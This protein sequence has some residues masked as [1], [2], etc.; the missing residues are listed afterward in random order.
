MNTQNSR[1]D[2]ME[3]LS[4][5]RIHIYP[6][7][8]EEILTVV[9]PI[10]VDTTTHY[11]HSSNYKSIIATPRSDFGN[12]SGIE[13]THIYSPSTSYQGFSPNTRRD[14]ATQYFI[15]IK[16]THTIAE[17]FLSEEEEDLSPD[18]RNNRPNSYLLTRTQEKAVVSA[19]SLS[20]SE[21]DIPESVTEVSEED[22]TLV[23]AHSESLVSYIIKN[24]L[25]EGAFV[26]AIV[27][28]KQYQSLIQTIKIYRK[29]HKKRDVAF[30]PLYSLVAY[31]KTK[32][33]P[34]VT[35]SPLYDH[36]AYPKQV[37]LSE[38]V[39][40]DI[41]KHVALKEYN[42]ISVAV[43]V[44]RE[45]QAKVTAYRFP[46]QSQF[47]VVSSTIRSS[48]TKMNHSNYLIA[49]G[50]STTFQT[51]GIPF[52]EVYPSSKAFPDVVDK[53][54]Y[55]TQFVRNNS[56]TSVVSQMKDLDGVLDIQMILGKDY[57][58][59]IE[60]GGF[61]FGIRGGSK[62][63]KEA[64]LVVRSVEEDSP[65]DICGLREGDNIWAI[66]GI[67]IAKM[68]LPKAESLY[69]E[70][71]KSHD[72]TVKI[73][74]A[75]KKP[76]FKTSETVVFHKSIEQLPQKTNN[77]FPNKGAYEDEYGVDNHTFSGTKSPD[78]GTEQS[79][80][81]SGKG[82]ALNVST[83]S[84]NNHLRSGAL[85]S[86]TTSVINSTVL[87]FSPTSD[88]TTRSGVNSNQS[89]SPRTASNTSLAS[90]GMGDYRVSSLGERKGRV[91]RL[92]DFVPEVDRAGDRSR[93]LVEEHYSSHEEGYSS[94]IYDPQHSQPKMI[95]NYNYKMI[96]KSSQYSY[97]PTTYNK[98]PP[99]NQ[100]YRQYSYDE[101]IPETG[102]EY[103]SRS[104]ENVSELQR[105]PVMEIHPQF[106]KNKSAKAGGGKRSSAARKS[107]E[108][109][110]KRSM[111]EVRDNDSYV[112]A[113]SRRQS[114][115][116]DSRE[117]VYH[118]VSESI[119]KKESHKKKKKVNLKRQEPVLL[120]RQVIQPEDWI[121][122]GVVRFYDRDF[123]QL[124][125]AY[126]YDEISSNTQLE[127]HDALRN[128]VKQQRLPAPG[129]PYSKNRIDADHRFEAVSKTIEVQK[130]RKEKENKVML[131]SPQI[132]EEPMVIDKEQV[133]AVSGKNICARCNQE[134]GR[135]AAMIIESLGL[136]FHLSCFRC[137]TCSTALGNGTKG[138]DVRVRD[139]KLFCQNCYHL[140]AP[141]H[142]HET[143]KISSHLNRIHI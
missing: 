46:A 138:A 55:K 11:D 39:F 57:H 71:I 108:R 111:E 7:D 52:D 50:A 112:T 103:I 119:L 125:H 127:D 24:A 93:G 8:R 23:E 25:E 102:K 128:I 106:R 143:T 134:L 21:I 130:A 41:K 53:Q 9:S 139:N 56:V 63:G 80:L 131:P 90:S 129:D 35:L 79:Q 105:C 19:S 49:P 88:T 109:S 86:P 85:G 6:E 68:S 78:F 121:S 77:H 67:S 40:S 92:T 30:I 91:G 99:P 45:Q 87:N 28:P 114:R 98:S 48:E 70:A 34:E 113:S 135:G 123:V 97:H 16:Q 10:S 13:S 32:K 58:K 74:R 20:S 61:G 76:Q 141:K 82:G 27:I 36:V 117:D 140:K 115:Y 44:Q 14:S 47:E 116:D 118:D 4:V 73:S 136:H 94:P 3:A 26:E 95:R 72:I 124:E 96:E 1:Y 37:K 12:D 84:P 122:D 62:K 83:T 43:E 54:L 89:L 120:E 18:F 66:N 2:R 42:K 15:P 110:V 126:S 22:T 132:Q 64:T 69:E 60:D 137:Q 33:V 65:A 59:N 142:H 107:I 38:L 104:L 51:I 101:D 100:Q 29:F 31:Q 133:M 75:A 5:L 17:D 81:V